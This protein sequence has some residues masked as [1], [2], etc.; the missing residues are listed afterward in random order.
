ML[1]R[2]EY[3]KEN[4]A[5][6][7]DLGI[8]EL[9]SVL[10][11]ISRTRDGHGRRI[12]SRSKVRKIVKRMNHDFHRASIQKIGRLTTTP[13]IISVATRLIRQH[14]AHHNLRCRDAIHLAI[15]LT[16]RLEDP[17]IC[18]VTNDKALAT[19]CQRLGLHADTSLLISA[20]EPDSVPDSSPN[21]T[22]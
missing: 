5:Y 15:V 2:I 11:R 22:A 19:L 3:A 20:I 4:E 1:E 14:G 9:T 16:R 8:L 17:S 21:V 13:A 6:V 7:S 12:L 18:L 10:M